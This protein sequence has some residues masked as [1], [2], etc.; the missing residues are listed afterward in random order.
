MNTKSSKKEIISLALATISIL[1]IAR[2]LVSPF[3]F[4]AGFEVGSC[5][6]VAVGC[7]GELYLHHHPAGRL[8]R[9]KDEHHR[10]ESLFIL[11]VVMG[12]TFESA[13]A[14]HTIEEGL[15]LQKEVEVLTTNNLQ[16]QI[17][18]ASAK[19]VTS[20]NEAQVA[21]F[22]TK[23]IELAHQYDL[24][25]NALAEANARLATIRPIKDRLIDWFNDFDPSILPSLRG[26]KTLFELQH[27]PEHKFNT[28][29]ALVH[30]W[31]IER[32]IAS[33]TNRSAGI[34][35]IQGIGTVKYF[36]VELKPELG[37]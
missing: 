13:A 9:Q 5:I 20:S 22:S 23:L 2:F 8:K 37:K 33:V 3:W 7:A 34:T 10:L 29:V 25:T 36:T 19:A 12:V 1:V 16:L 15:K 35:V 27:V 31:G 6:L 4:W 11:A 21:I 26:G 30:E 24:S 32:Y 17:D 18:V 14:A 28:F